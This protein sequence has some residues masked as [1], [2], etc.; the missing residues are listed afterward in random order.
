MVKVSDVSPDFSDFPFDHE[1]TEDSVRTLICQGG[2]ELTGSCSGDVI[3]RDGKMFFR[4][5]YYQKSIDAVKREHV[6]LMQ[7]QKY[8]FVPRVYCLKEFGRYTV[9]FTELIK[10]V[11]LDKLQ[12][13]DRR[14][15]YGI[16]EGFKL[17]HRLYYDL[18]FVHRDLHA[19]NILIDE[20]DKVY[21]ID[22]T[23]SDIPLMLEDKG[24]WDRDFCV[25]IESLTCE[26]SEEAVNE[27]YDCDIVP[28]SIDPE[29]YLTYIM[30]YIMS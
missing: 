21:L 7:L 10:A 1:L 4:A 29:L 20:N 2:C 19:G 6:I 18:G 3:G 9:I 24:S 22:F 26:Q 23:E 16:K 27:C 11:D 13:N 30:K 17:T 25:C 28:M 12:H 5:G 8:D 14:F 15:K